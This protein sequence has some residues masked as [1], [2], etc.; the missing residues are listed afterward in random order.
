MRLRYFIRPF[1]GKMRVS[2]FLPSANMYE[3][4]STL[5]DMARKKDHNVTVRYLLPYSQD[6]WEFL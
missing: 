2:V 1:E 5:Y 4:S 6:L 3:Y